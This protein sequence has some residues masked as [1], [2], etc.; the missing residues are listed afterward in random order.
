MARCVVAAD[1]RLNCHVEVVNLGSC[2]HAVLAME[3]PRWEDFK[4]ETLDAMKNRFFWLG[5]GSTHNE[6]YQTGDRAY[7]EQ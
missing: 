5:D 3:H 4:Y 7:I 1:M 6:K 2:L